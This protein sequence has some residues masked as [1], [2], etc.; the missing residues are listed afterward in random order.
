MSV[1][2]PQR[3]T[4]EQ[5]IEGA[6]RAIGKHGPAK[7][8]LAHVADEVGVTAGA[9]VQRFG[10]KQGLLLA[11]GE[12]SGSTIEA[13]VYAA[14]ARRTP[15][16]ALE[17]FLVRQV[18]ALR[19]REQ[20]ANHMAFLHLDLANPELRARAQQHARALL[21]A[22]RRL[23]GAAVDAGELRDGDLDERAV[24]VYTTYNGALI[25]SALVGKGSLTSWLRSQLRVALAPYRCDA[26]LPGR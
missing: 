2:R 20:M 15:L 11:I 24:S 19:S 17:H 21:A 12:V 10:S 1:G 18:R 16:R 3:V 5:I 8:T 7:L 9:I 6:V 14:L 4:D 13:E 23:L 26:P 22:I 25:S